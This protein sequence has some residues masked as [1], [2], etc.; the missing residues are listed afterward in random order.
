MA[1]VRLKTVLD[2]LGRGLPV[3]RLGYILKPETSAFPTF[4]SDRRGH[5]LRAA[6]AEP[7]LGIRPWVAGERYPGSSVPALLAAQ[8]ARR[9]GEEVA[10]AFHFSLF[11]T[12][13]VENRDISEPAVLEEVAL[14]SHIALDRFRID[15]QDPKVKEVVYAEHLE[16]IDRWRIEAVPTIIIGRNRIEGAVPRTQYQAALTQLADDRDIRED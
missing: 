13:L 15:Y 14:A 9:Q 10:D 3:R 4:S 7:A 11:R 8:A 16:A 12:F 2:S 6:A 1:E 5:W